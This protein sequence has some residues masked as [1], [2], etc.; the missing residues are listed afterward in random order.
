M[1][2]CDSVVC[3]CVKT[4][5]WN[6]ITRKGWGLRFLFSYLLVYYF[7]SYLV[8]VYA[9]VCVL[10]I[11]AFLRGGGGGGGDN[12]KLASPSPTC[13]ND[14]TPLAF[15]S[16]TYLLVIRYVPGPGV[17]SSLPSGVAFRDTLIDVYRAS[18][19]VGC[20][21]TDETPLLRHKAVK[22]KRMTL[23]TTVENLWVWCL[24]YYHISIYY[25][26]LPI[27]LQRRW[28]A[29]CGLCV[30]EFCFFWKSRSGL[31]VYTLH[32]VFQIFVWLF[33]T[34][35]SYHWLRFHQPLSLIILSVCMNPNYFS[36]V[37]MTDRWRLALYYFLRKGRTCTDQLTARVGW[38][39][40]VSPVSRGR[41]RESERGTTL[42]CVPSTLP[43]SYY[44]LCTYIPVCRTQSNLHVKTSMDWHTVSQYDDAWMT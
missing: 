7:F 12:R 18:L 14:P 23:M 5:L 6:C 36:Y 24:M 38:T 44:M 21:Q 2:V 3:V 1:R 37:K 28:T 27:N 8:Y 35:V 30:F 22:T 31:Y 34:R 25:S 16:R 19:T 4:D 42:H 43:Q 39:S 17:V 26:V 40:A 15:F 13:I 20:E 29:A 33:L 41:E 9:C 10:L 32:Y 11:S